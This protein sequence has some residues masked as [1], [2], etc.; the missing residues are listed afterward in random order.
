MLSGGDAL[1]SMLGLA[2]SATSETPTPETPTP[3]TYV[4]CAVLQDASG[5]HVR[6]GSAKYYP[7]SMMYKRSE[8]SVA[9]KESSRSEADGLYR[10][11]G[12]VYAVF[13]SEQYAK[14]QQRPEVP[15]APAVAATGS[16]LS[17]P[18]VVSTPE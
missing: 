4:L 8:G 2:D 15:A 17:V 18:L 9:I 16:A 12:I 14:T 13:T 10:E 6:L 1:R 5:T 3:E 11:N 7:V